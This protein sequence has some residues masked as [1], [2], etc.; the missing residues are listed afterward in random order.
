[1]IF[2]IF[3]F[4]TISSSIQQVDDANQVAKYFLD[5]FEKIVKTNDSDLL[6]S[7]LVDGFEIT[8][9]NI[10][11]KTTVNITQTIIQLENN[12]SIALKNAVIDNENGVV[13]FVVKLHSGIEFD[14]EFL[15]KK[16]GNSWN[17]TKSRFGEENCEEKHNIFIK[18]VRSEWLEE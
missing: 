11:M 9:E 17:L 8:C 18:F 3:F 14:I 5:T 15:G 2:S 16:F 6:S 7:I 10:L 12:Q 13:N 4:L 1:M